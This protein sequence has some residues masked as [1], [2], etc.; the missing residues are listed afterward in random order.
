MSLGKAAESVG[1]G[2]AEDDP[3]PMASMRAFAK[4]S[5]SGDGGSPSFCCS[6]WS[7]G[8]PPSLVLSSAIS[9]YVDERIVKDR[10]NKL[11]D[12]RHTC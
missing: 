12:Q 3:F 2:G 7:C 11:T 4:A 10:E 5:N 1:A 6:F 9:R 8:I